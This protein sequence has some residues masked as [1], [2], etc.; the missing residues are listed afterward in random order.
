MP[1]SNPTYPP[2]LLLPRD[3]KQAATILVQ[4]LPV[5]TTP[6]RGQTVEHVTLEVRR[7]ARPGGMARSLTGTTAQELTGG[8]EVSARVPACAYD[9]VTGYLSGRMG[10]GWTEA[11]LTRRVTY[12]VQNAVAYYD[13]RCSRDSLYVYIRKLQEDCPADNLEMDMAEEEAVTG[14]HSALKEMDAEDIKHWW[15]WLSVWGGLR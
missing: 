6:I 15:M 9:P 13:L 12:M 4:H 11:Q 2:L 1:N 14:Y 10:P 3:P 5:D 7:L 8:V